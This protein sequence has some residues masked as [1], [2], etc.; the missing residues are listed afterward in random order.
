MIWLRA[1]PL[2]VFPAIMYAAVAMTMDP[3]GVR[4]SLD[5]IFL[6]LT[7]PSGANFVVTRGHGLTMLAAGMLFLEIIK[8]THA[9][10]AAL[11]ENGLAFVAFVIAFILFLL[12]PA[13]GTIEFA[14]IM[15]MMLVD[16]MAG[17]IVMTV[18]SRRDVAFGDGGA[19]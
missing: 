6:S 11:V 8:S 7:L 13:F 19:T 1:V 3:A 12:N 14:L 2:L 17:F 5:Q 4:G 18:S 9:N 10:T 16:F 15:V